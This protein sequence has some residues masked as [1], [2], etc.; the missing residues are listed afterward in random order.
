MATHV[1]L[2][3]AVNVGGTGKLPMAELRTLCEKAGFTGVRTYIASGNVILG[4]TLGAAKVK[5]TLEALLRTR[6][7]KPCAVMVRTPGDLDAVLGANPYADADPSRTLVLFLPE[8]PPKAARDA[9]ASWRIPGRE[10]FALHGRELF[11][12]FPDG[13]GTSKLK[14]PFADIGTGRNVNT[15]RA[16]LAMARDDA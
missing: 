4:S 16:L 1:A 10:R 2:L 9:L 13:M 3:R 8:A 6:L 15:I 7:G 11:M 12:H 5:S 14:I